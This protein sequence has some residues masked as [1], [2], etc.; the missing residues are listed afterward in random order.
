MY[1]INS[2]YL[3]LNAPLGIKE[4]KKPIDEDNDSEFRV[5]GLMDK[6][7]KNYKKAVCENIIVNSP[8]EN[9]LLWKSRL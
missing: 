4:E 1:R 3:S 8:K 6:S 7:N 2:I 9:L 5:C